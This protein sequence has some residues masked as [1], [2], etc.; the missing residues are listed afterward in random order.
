MFKTILS[1]LGSVAAT[2]AVVWFPN[3]EFGSTSVWEKIGIS[4]LMLPVFFV[5]IYIASTILPFVLSLA[6]GGSGG[7]LIEPK[8]PPRNGLPYSGR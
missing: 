7:G 2:I 6:F 4:P 1:G 3:E 8:G 5:A